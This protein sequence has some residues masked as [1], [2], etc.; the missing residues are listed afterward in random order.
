MRRKSLQRPLYGQ[1]SSHQ[2]P[3]TNARAALDTSFLFVRKSASPCISEKSNVSTA[4]ATN[5]RTI[6]NWELKSFLDK[7][8]ARACCA[9]GFKLG[10][11]TCF[12]QATCKGMLH[13][14]HNIALPSMRR[15]AWPAHRVC[16]AC[17]QRSRKRCMDSCGNVMSCCIREC[18]QPPVGC[19]PF[20]DGVHFEAD[21]S[22]TV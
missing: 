14:E 1:L 11:K 21:I 16:A 6:L 3:V 20:A 9:Y 2:H 17:S 8:H 7:Q 4:A 22:S 19:T 5:D 15:R 18:V 12:R 13:N 10:I